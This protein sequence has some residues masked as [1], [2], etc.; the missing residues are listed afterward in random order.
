MLGKKVYKT[1]KK[2]IYFFSLV[3]FNYVSFYLSCTFIFAVLL[4]SD[5]DFF[6]AVFCTFAN[7]SG[8]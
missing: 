1:M 3:S 6:D 4:N 2:I 5:K 8:Q 7:Y